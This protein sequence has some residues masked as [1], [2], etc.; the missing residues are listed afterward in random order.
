VSFRRL[1]PVALALAA[2]CVGACYDRQTKEAGS[3]KATMIGTTTLTWH[4]RKIAPAGITLDFLSGPPFMEGTFEGFSYVYQTMDPILL[5]VW[6]G[7]K[8]DLAGFRASFGP[9]EPAIFGPEEGARTCGRPARRQ[10]ATVP[11][12]SGAVG[13]VREQDGSLGHI[14]TRT[15]ARTHVAVAFQHHGVDVLVRFQVDTPSREAWHA[16]EQRFFSSIVCD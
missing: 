8:Q 15:K 2:G 9:N 12:G 16:A 1:S 3:E 10:V 6:F 14:Y 5:G 7:P 13:L 4:S 11:E